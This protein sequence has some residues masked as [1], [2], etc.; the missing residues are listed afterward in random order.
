M[1][2]IALCGSNAIR[3]LYVCF[4]F[5]FASNFIVMLPLFCQFA[6]C[7]CHHKLLICFSH[8]TIPSS[9][10]LC[11]D[12]TF[13]TFI[14]FPLHSIFQTIRMTFY[15]AIATRTYPFTPYLF[16]T[17]HLYS[18]VWLQR[19]SHNH[20]LC[21]RHAIR[22][23]GPILQVLSNTTH[24]TIL[25]T[26][27]YICLPKKLLMPTVW[28]QLQSHNFCHNT[29]AM[30]TQFYDKAIPLYQKAEHINNARR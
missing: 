12:S 27:H 5:S 16:F 3:N 10:F 6:N 28:L 25:P 2:I 13:L 24:T 20:W 8:V 11:V 23:T 17:C 26:T 18:F 14:H 9:C 29:P 4:I 19:Q 7:K 21:Q 15:F 1:F 30:P 22:T